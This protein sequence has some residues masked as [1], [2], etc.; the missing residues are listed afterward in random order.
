M[1]VGQ[2]ENNLA[3]NPSNEKL[4]TSPLELIVSATEKKIVMLESG[5]QELT[6]EELAKAIEQMSLKNGWELPLVVGVPQPGEGELISKRMLTQELADNYSGPI[7]MWPRGDH[8]AQNDITRGIENGAAITNANLD[9]YHGHT[10]ATA[11]FPNG[12]YHYHITSAD[13]YING[14]GFYGTPGTV[15]Q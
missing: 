6:N 3:C 14:S 5:A 11:D 4:N 10:H 12:I 9:A 1:I 13:P 2:V 7:V 8:S 15:S